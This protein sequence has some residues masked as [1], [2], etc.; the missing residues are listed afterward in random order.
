MLAA[1]AACCFASG[2]H[3]LAGHMTWPCLCT[4]AA[5][6]HWCWCACSGHLLRGHP[7]SESNAPPAPKQLP[8]LSTPRVAYEKAFSVLVAHM[9]S[10][11]IC[12]CMTEYLVALLPQHGVGQQVNGTRLST[13]GRATRRG[14]CP[15]YTHATHC[16]PHE[17]V[18]TPK[19]STETTKYPT[20]AWSGFGASTALARR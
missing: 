2:H 19:H 1:S 13:R 11:Y 10:M 8:S 4:P 16:V 18:L 5:G 15:V 3:W 17:A 14:G 12:M 20:G 9:P 7:L 6:M